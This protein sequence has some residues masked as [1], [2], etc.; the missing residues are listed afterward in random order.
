MMESDRLTQPVATASVVPDNSSTANFWKLWAANGFSNLG[1]GLYQITLPLIALQ[2][3]S[4]PTRIATLSVLLSL[5]WLLFALQAGSIVDRF[6]R[7]K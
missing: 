6:D 3:T 4:S 7:H 1:D 2:L 5:P